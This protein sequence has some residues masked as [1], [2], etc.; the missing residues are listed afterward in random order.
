MLARYSTT[1]RRSPVASCATLLLTGVLAPAA[2]SQGISATAKPVA[3]APANEIAA[4]KRR[5]DEL[6]R[7]VKELEKEKAEEVKQEKEDDALARRLGQRLDAIEAAQKQ[8]DGGAGRASAT[9]TDQSGPLTVTAPFI[10]RDHEGKTIL[11]VDRP[12]KGG[13][14]LTV[15]NLVGASVQLGASVEGESVIYMSDAG[16]KVR[17]MAQASAQ[18][19]SFNTI[20]RNGRATLGNGDDGNPF[21]AIIN[22]SDLSI[23]ELR[24]MEA[25]SGR[26]VIANAAGEKLVVAGVASSGV[27]VVKTGPGG[28]GAAAVMGNIALPASEIQGRKR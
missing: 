22:K 26:L 1:L 20:G 13:A 18:R 27:G 21:V 28:L 12:S 4:L 24:G 16:N 9:D 17:L 25:Q 5:V 19:V 7:R 11:R 3:S 15:G 8:D 14:R 10:V 6:D 23:A 2:L